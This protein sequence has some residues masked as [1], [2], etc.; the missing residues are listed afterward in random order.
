MLYSTFS[1]SLVVYFDNLRYNLAYNNLSLQSETMPTLLPSTQS[2]ENALSHTAV[3][4]EPVKERCRLD[5]Q[6]PQV[7]GIIGKTQEWNLL[8]RSLYLGQGKSTLI[9]GDEGLGKSFFLN[10]YFKALST[11]PFSS[12]D[13]AP[14]QGIMIRLT[15]LPKSTWQTWELNQLLKESLILWTEGILT[16]VQ[17]QAN[18]HLAPLDLALGRDPLHLLM[19]EFNTT[20]DPQERRSRWEVFL[21][22]ALARKQNLI[23]KWT[24]SSQEAIESA[25]TFLNQD[26]GFVAFHLKNTLSTNTKALDVE[27]L[28]QS[29]AEWMKQYGVNSPVPYSFSMIIDAWDMVL[30]QTYPQQKKNVTQ[31][32]TLLKSLNQKKQAPIYLTLATRP[33]GLSQQFGANTYTS[34]RD[35]HLLSPYSAD[36]IQSLLT[37]YAKDELISLALPEAFY[38]LTQGRADYALDLYKAWVKQSKQLDLPQ[39]T[40]ESFEALALE[41]IEDLEA[42]LYVRLQLDALQQGVGFLKALQVVVAHL[43]LTP[44]SVEGF[45]LDRMINPPQGVSEAQLAL[46]LRKLYLY[47]VIEAVPENELPASVANKKI[48]LYRLISR[49]ALQGLYGFFLPKEVE[50]IYQS[51]RNTLSPSSDSRSRILNEQEHHAQADALLRLLPKTFEEGELTLEK[52]RSVLAHLQTLHQDEKTRHVQTLF[53][54]F[55]HASRLAVLEARRVEAVSFLGHLPHAKVPLVL[56]EELES[57]TGLIQQALLKSLKQW[58]HTAKHSH[59]SC[60]TVAADVIETLFA[61]LVPPQGL[62]KKETVLVQSLVFDALT[63]WSPFDPKGVFKALRQFLQNALETQSESLLSVGLLRCIQQLLRPF[64]AQDVQSNMP[65][66]TPIVL[67][68]LEEDH[69]QTEAL[70]LLPYVSPDNSHL[71]HLLQRLLIQPLHL[72][73]SWKLFQH[74]TTHL[75]AFPFLHQALFDKIASVLDVK[76]RSEALPVDAQHRLIKHLLLHL[77]QVQ[78]SWSSTHQETLADLLDESLSQSTWEQ[79]LDLLWL[80]LRLE[81]AVRQGHSK[82]VPKWMTRLNTSPSS[83]LVKQLL[84]PML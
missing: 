58:S 13:F 11:N 44:F 54:L 45:L 67:K 25:V 46:A 79:S 70:P 71:Q 20:L 28:L 50:A 74:V 24:T 29:L 49:R 19:Q 84:K 21:K 38:A 63:S 81:K 82:Q 23:Q 60:D 66:L 3:A 73:S 34:F 75:E 2:Y 57:A 72:L 77:I 59:L 12:H 61:K 1:V 5:A 78:S 37:L 43:D 16:Q 64:Q 65:W 47:Q 53:D 41:S 26:W 14:H 35:K 83:Q 36:E 52:F 62:P 15:D 56:V 48:P 69:L 9:M 39:P 8:S 80:A 10:A 55:S 22:K 76:T 31:L 32:H 6:S 42:L 27:T 33:Q 51:T 68:A 17:R 40:L 18:Q 30:I 4:E 7:F